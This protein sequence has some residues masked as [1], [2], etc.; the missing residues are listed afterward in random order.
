MDKE[1]LRAYTAR[2]SQANKSGLVVIVYEL[3]S[4]SMDM[5]GQAFNN[6]DRD[7]AVKH[8]RKAQ[9]CVCE[10]KRS[11]DFHYGIS[12]N[13]ASLYRYVNGL[14]V[15]AITRREPSGFN[16]IKKVMESLHSAFVEVAKQDTSEAVM[17]NT[18]QVYAGLTYG[19]G[20]LDE[21]FMNVN[22]RSRGFM[23]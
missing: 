5:A 10:L 17:Q 23:A 11:L 7:R 8:L 14:L 22:E 2:I 18:Q 16:E 21:V 15:T 6:G 20:K 4:Y 13:L 3:F 19:K 12:Y 9:E 1:L